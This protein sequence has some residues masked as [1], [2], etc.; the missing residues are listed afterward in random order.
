MTQTFH[1]L[2]LHAATRIPYLRADGFNISVDL[3]TL[4]FG[5]DCIHDALLRLVYLPVALFEENC[6]RRLLLEL[7]V[8]V[9]DR[10]LPA[11]AFCALHAAQGLR[12]FSCGWRFILQFS[13]DSSSMALHSCVWHGR[14]TF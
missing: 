14:G 12:H 2:D 7:L 6:W 3:R 10:Q 13:D 4:R 5:M 9:W 1:S 8:L 11:R